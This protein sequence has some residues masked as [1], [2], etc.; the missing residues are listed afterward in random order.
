MSFM[1]G[2]LLTKTRKLVK[3]LAKAEPTWLKAME[4]FVFPSP[5]IYS[6]LYIHCLRCVFVGIFSQQIL[7]N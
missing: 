7:Q 6:S 2:N 3:G 4:E 5:Y 1:K